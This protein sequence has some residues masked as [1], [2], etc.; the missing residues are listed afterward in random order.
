MWKHEQEIAIMIITMRYVL[1]I[2]IL[3]N[4]KSRLSLNPKMLIM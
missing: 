2:A 4:M 3:R 1:S